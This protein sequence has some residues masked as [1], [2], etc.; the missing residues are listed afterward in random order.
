MAPHG[1]TS[2]FSRYFT[3]HTGGKSVA[4][5]GIL[6]AGHVWA[7]DTPVVVHLTGL[8]HFDAHAVVSNGTQYFS[9][10]DSASM[11]D[12]F[13]FRRARL[14]VKGTVSEGIAYEVILNATGSDTHWMDTGF[15]TFGT[16]PSLQWRFGRFR[17]PF[18]LEAMTRD[19]NTDFME[20]SYGDQL[21]PN[22]LLGIMALGEPAKGVTYGASLAQSGFNQITS[23]RKFGGLYTGRL[24][25][26]AAAWKDMPHQVMHFGVSTHAGTAYIMPTTSSNTGTSASGTTRATILNFRTEDR[27]YAS[28]YRA[29]L[30]GDKLTSYSY[31]T[32]AD[33]V[34]TV[35][36]QLQDIEFAYAR[37]AWK[38][39]SEYSHM[40]MTASAYDSYSAKTQSMSLNVR[41]FYHEIFYNLTGENWTDAYKSGSFV[42]IKPRSNFQFAKGG[43]G[44]WQTGIRY[45]AYK[46]SL[47][48]TTT[49]CSSSCFADGGNQNSR[50]ENSEK[51]HTI[52][53]GLNWW[54][55][56]NTAFKMN[57]AVTRF[58]RPVSVLSTNSS[59]TFTRED[60]LSVRVQLNF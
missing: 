5:L 18:S 38:F 58:D 9:D 21:G 59:D 57:Y 8:V 10:K 45:S 3:S 24:T 7:V 40:A 60:V 52:T 56:P 44:A 42:G 48:G 35:N 26:N 19:A 51:A 49:A 30:A 50:V 46:V 33:N 31:G 32:S 4:I 12:Q 54:L 25:A 15:M 11:A 23:A 17:Q 36:K 34:A 1:L 2:M 22:K 41:T 28:A 53:L 55:N 37:G 14:G 20:R 39:Q 13:E 6:C 47:P 16:D 43:S 27:G 29:Q